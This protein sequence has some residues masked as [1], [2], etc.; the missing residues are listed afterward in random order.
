[1]FKQFIQNV[2]NRKVDNDQILV[3]FFLVLQDEE[4]NVVFNSEEINLERLKYLLRP[5]KF[6]R[7]ELFVSLEK[8]FRRV[9]LTMKQLRN[10]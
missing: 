4:K 1:M 5:L 8:M 2:E 3:A 6:Q 9:K 10:E 7:P